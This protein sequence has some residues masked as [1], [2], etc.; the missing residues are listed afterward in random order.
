[1]SITQDNI[2]AIWV[3]LLSRAK[4]GDDGNGLNL[5]SPRRGKG[6][7]REYSPKPQIGVF[8]PLKIFHL[9]GFPS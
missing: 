8:Y 7:Q 9:F 3:L 6:T 4:N 1:M 5:D 2:S